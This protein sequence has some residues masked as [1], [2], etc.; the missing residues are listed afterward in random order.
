MPRY[1]TII[2]GVTDDSGVDNSRCRLARQQQKEQQRVLRA[3]VVLRGAGSGGAGAAG[4][5]CLLLLLLLLRCCH[6][7]KQ[8]RV[9]GVRACTPEL[10]CIEIASYDTMLLTTLCVRILHNIKANFV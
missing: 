5:V 3:D 4:G 6:C 10:L 9:A 1:A 7:Q 8:V 2:Y